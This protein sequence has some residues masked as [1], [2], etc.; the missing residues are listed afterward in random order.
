MIP[1]CPNKLY[2]VDKRYGLI[3]LT[4][5]RILADLTGA[6][7]H[8]HINY[9]NCQ[10]QPLEAKLTMIALTKRR[11]NRSFAHECIVVVISD[12]EKKDEK[13]FW[14]LNGGLTSLDR[15]LLALDNTVITC[16]RTIPLRPRWKRIQSYGNAGESSREIV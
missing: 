8:K 16:Y 9:H 13:A 1:V 5:R 3:H 6:Y 2:W 15:G 12:T 7:L 11:M 4:H 10:A 14:V